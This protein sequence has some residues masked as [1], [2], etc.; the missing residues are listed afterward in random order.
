M[1][2]EMFVFVIRKTKGCDLL[3]A[4]SKLGWVRNQLVLR[5]TVKILI[6]S[7]ANHHNVISADK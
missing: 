7:C 6:P 3:A 1:Q 5:R 2:G 4:R